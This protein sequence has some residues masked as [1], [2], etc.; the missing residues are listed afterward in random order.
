M[1]L[2]IAACTQKEM[3]KII[4][5]PQKRRPSWQ[6]L[7]TAEYAEGIYILLFHRPRSSVYLRVLR[8]ERV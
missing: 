7:F 2:A 8:G 6:D 5:R 1:Y 4:G 3:H